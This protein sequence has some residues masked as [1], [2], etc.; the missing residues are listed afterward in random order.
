MRR[1]VKPVEFETCY[2]MSV[3]L[4]KSASVQ[5]RTGPLSLVVQ[6]T[7]AVFEN[8]HLLF[9]YSPSCHNHSAR[10]CRLPP[11]QRLAISLFS[12]KKWQL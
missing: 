8:G 7:N 10:V 3:D 5:P 11:A 9:T 1:C 2:K 4:Q 12:F 6:G